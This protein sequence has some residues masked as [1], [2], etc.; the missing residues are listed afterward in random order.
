METRKRTPLELFNLPQ[1]FVIPLF[2][3]PYVWEEGDQWAPLWKDIRR[4]V[5]T[6][7]AASSST[8]THFLGAV[9]LQAAEASPG[10]LTTWNVI[11]GQQRLTTLQLLMD[12]THALLVTRGLTSL[13]S[14][15]EGL[16][17]NPAHFVPTGSSALKVRHLNRDQAAFDEVMNAEPSVDYES[18]DHDDS[19]LVRAH[20]Y[21]R[22][23]V[24]EWLGETD[25]PDHDSRAE[26]LAEVLQ[27]GLQLVSIDLTPAED[28][29]E[30]FETLNAR[31]TPL[32]ASDLVRNFVFQRLESEGANSKEAYEKDWP[33]E[34]KFWEAEVSVGRQSVSRSSLF[35]NQW[36]I[37]RTGDEVS[38]LNTFSAFK[39][40]VEHTDDVSITGLLP[41]LRDQADLYQ[42]WTE[43]AARPDGNLPVVPMA[44]YRMKASGVELLKPLLIWLTDPSR[45]V[46][47]SVIQEVVRSAESWIYRRQLLR[48]S[49]S[50]LGRIV[51]EIIRTYDKTPSHELPERI[52]AHLSRLNVTST[53]WPSDAE[54]RMA[55][56]MEPAYRRYPRGRL[57]M[58][59]EAIEDYYRNET[60]QP[61]VERGKLPIEHVLPQK[62]Q[63]SWPLGE[64]DDPNTRTDHVHRIGN[65]TLLT[66]SLNSRVSNGPWARK[67]AEL[68]KHNTMTMTGRLIEKTEDRTWN[69]SLIDARSGELIETLLRTWPVPDGHVGVVVDPQAKAGEWIEVKHLLEAGL[70]SPGD[71]LVATHRDFPGATARVLPN[72]YLEVEGRHHAS[73][74]AAAK[75]LRQ[76]ATN[77]WYFWGLGDGRR[78]RDVRTEFLAERQ[79][80]ADG[81]QTSREQSGVQR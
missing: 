76:S 49:N 39:S 77:G 63:D 55:L 48:L 78:L 19:R 81:T 50:D 59:L 26:R 34:T 57:R 12:A 31:G 40:Y 58:F 66:R 36:L 3:R 25:D 17:H 52:A 33:F 30:I 13:A 38:P 18:L 11:D 35:L 8:P 46:S 69:E 14:Q 2:Q 73:P 41:Q 4:T 56:A 20:R 21:F 1:H 72:G 7:L 67:R 15:L 37:S 16:T 29:Q 80:S 60:G 28:S 45:A 54:V 51:A 71:E 74:S 70:L 53:Y 44:V 47:P 75:A 62:W 43:A 6:R 5:E 9:V 42:A 24:A 32:T 64:L 68:L 79:H 10:S 61:Q 27:A 65:L 22:S 23:V